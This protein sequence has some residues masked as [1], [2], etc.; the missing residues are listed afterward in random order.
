VFN[1]DRMGAKL[2]R[3]IA[4]LQHRVLLAT[5]RE[6]SRGMHY[7]TS[8]D[9]FFGSYM[10]LGELYRYPTKHFEFHRRQLTFGSSVR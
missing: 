1:H 2:D 7:P 9:P 10:T 8:W 6:L 5:N 3:V 4:K